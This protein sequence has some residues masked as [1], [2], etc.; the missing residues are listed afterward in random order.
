MFLKV[1]GFLDKVL[2]FIAPKIIGGIDSI[3]SVGGRSP[4]LIKSAIRLR[5]VQIK[6]FGD[7]LLLEGYPVFKR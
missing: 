3:P 2:A 6:R 7:D 5:D 1:L 4:A